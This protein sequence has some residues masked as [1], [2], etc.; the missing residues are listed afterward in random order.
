MDSDYHSSRAKP[1]IYSPSRPCMRRCTCFEDCSRRRCYRPDRNDPLQLGKR[2]RQSTSHRLVSSHLKEML[3]IARVQVSS[4]FCKGTPNCYLVY[5]IPIPHVWCNSALGQKRT[6]LWQQLVWKTL[7]IAR[8]CRLDGGE[9]AP[10]RAWLGR[11]YLGP[12][13]QEGRDHDENN[14]QPLAHGSLNPP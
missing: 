10:G 14:G 5:P 9:I 1:Q 2:P 3:R 4:L 8:Y 7:H 13:N 11:Y 12:N 6:S